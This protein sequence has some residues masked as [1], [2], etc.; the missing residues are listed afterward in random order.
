MKLSRAIANT[1]RP[2]VYKKRLAEMQKHPLY[3]T[4][5]EDY[6]DQYVA[7]VGERYMDA[8]N[9]CPDT[10]VLLE[11][12]LDFSLWVPEGFG[13][14]DVIIISD[15]AIEVI[16]LK[17]GQGVPVSA[18]ANP[19]TRL[20]GLGALNT[21][22]SLYA[23][24]KVRMTIIQPRLDSTSTEELS[25]DQLARWAEEELVPKAAL[26]YAGEGEFCAGEH[27]KFCKAKTTCRQSRG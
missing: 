14:G 22:E 15:E 26:A 6:V 25:I 20:Y 7:Q 21:F 23:F 5:M 4:G 11:Q 24:E 3:S 19:Q 9:K 12:R 8:K 2:S 13:T 17:Y 10:L 1:I 18:I 16:D 27:C